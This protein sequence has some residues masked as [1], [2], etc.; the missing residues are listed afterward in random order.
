MELVMHADSRSI[1][2]AYHPSTTI[3]EYEKVSCASSSHRLQSEL[4]II[5][6]DGCEDAID[7]E[8][9]LQDNTKD[10]QKSDSGGKVKLKFLNGLR[11]MAS[12]MIV[13]THAGYLK[14]STIA[15]SGVDI[16]FVLSAFLLTML[17]EPKINKLV[18]HRDGP[19]KWLI[20]LLDYFV[21]RI[22]R[23]YP[24]FASV[25][26]IL[27]CMPEKTRTHYYNLAHYHIQHWSLWEILTF[28]RR[29]YLFWT[30]PIEITYYFIIP[31]FLLGVCL[32]GKFKWLAIGPLYIWVYYEGGH[33]YRGG[34]GEFRPQLST[35]VA[36]SLAAVVC[37]ALSKT[38]KKCLFEPRIW[39]LGII[40]CFELTM[41]SCMLS[42]ISRGDF[43]QWF[44]LFPSPDPVVPSVSLPVSAIIVIETLL[45]SAISRALEWNFLCYTGKISFSMYLLHPFVNFLPFLT[46]L[47]R[48]DQFVVRLILVYALATV[49][50]FLIERP[51]QRLAITIGKKLARYAVSAPAR[52]E[53]T[54]QSLVARLVAS[55]R[56]TDADP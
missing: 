11:G 20:T 30:L 47:Q 55:L 39:Q 10:E 5:V 45:P 37:S 7:V 38:M 18:A 6:V 27:T 36:G 34:H 12:L 29:Y 4:P 28:Q 51:S 48:I 49:S 31:V 22:L 41:V 1:N 19:R 2:D 54:S 42:N 40:R 15:P 16:F 17:N 43:K 23:V 13:H 33:I 53:A 8:V 9:K 44:R 21:K 24:L 26:F 3:H 56:P 25:A 32:L 52:V 50:Y 14:E 35:F 46:K